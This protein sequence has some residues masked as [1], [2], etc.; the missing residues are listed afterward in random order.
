MTYGAL[1]ESVLLPAYDLAR[2]RNY[3]ARRRFLEGS[4]WWSAERLRAFQWIE[5][6]KILRHAFASVPY[7]QQKYRAAGIA[8]DDV[9]T[10]DDFRQLPTLTRAEVNAHGR[11]LCSTSYAGRLLPHATGGSTGTPTRFFRTYESYDWRTAA[12]DR[13]YSWAGWRLGERALYLWGAPVGSVSRRQAWKTRAH[14]AVQRQLVISTFSQSDALWDD[15]YAR[16]VR[17]RPIVV[18]GYVSS[19]EACAAYLRRTARTIPGLTCAIAAAEPLFEETRKRIERGLGVPLAN[20]YGSREFMSIAAECACQQGLHVHAE[21]LVVET[22]EARS[23]EPSEI[24]VTDLHNYG[25]PFIRYETGDLGTM[26]GGACG[27]GRG[28]P[29][30]NAVDGRML[31]ALRTVDG[32]TVPGEFFPHLLKEIPELAQYRVE[33]TRLDRL[34][35]SAVLTSPLSDRS[36]ALLR[37]EIGKVFGSGTVYELQPVVDIPALSSG[38]RRVTVGLPLEDRRW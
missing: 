11:E 36:S 19:L 26:A 5:L 13:A 25:M 32:R 4:Q 29:R 30:L 24:L 31:D 15:V 17:F 20:T 21:N 1:L 14:E 35:I 6:K 12:K 3:L 34:V 33:Q 10:W 23:C 27:C 28:L 7:L 8:L 38:K 2:G 18:V 37:R 9:R 22:R 16:A